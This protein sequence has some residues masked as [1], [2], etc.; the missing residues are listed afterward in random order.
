MLQ[1]HITQGDIYGAAVTVS[2][3]TQDERGSSKVLYGTSENKLE[4][5]A[6]GKV[7]HYKYYTYTSG[8]IHH[9]TLRKLKVSL[10]DSQS[11]L[12]LI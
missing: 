12:R 4:F 7:T 1:V 9:C 6:E 10:F 8:F 11:S 5:S 2:W 3:V